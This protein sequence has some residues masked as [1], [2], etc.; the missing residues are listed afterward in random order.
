MEYNFYI[1]AGG[2]HFIQRFNKLSDKIE[3]VSLT[4]QKTYK[5]F[6]C[7]QEFKDYIDATCVS[8]SSY[9]Y[10]TENLWRKDGEE[11]IFDDDAQIDPE[12]GLPVD[13]SDIRVITHYSQCPIY[14]F[15]FEDP[16]YPFFTYTT[17]GNYNQITS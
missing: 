10:D 15:I 5:D 11:I 9:E 17:A 13:S 8:N 4:G 6:S 16:D 1:Y 3:Y 14:K 7:M 12:T 2:V